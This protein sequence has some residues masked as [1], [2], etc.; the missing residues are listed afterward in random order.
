MI[1]IP[2]W[3]DT[4]FGGSPE[5]QLLIPLAM[6][7]ND[8]NLSGS[9][10]IAAN[11]DN[12]GGMPNLLMASASA[13]QNSDP[14]ISLEQEEVS[15]QSNGHRFRFSLGVGFRNDTLLWNIADIDNSPNILSELEWNDFRSTVFSGQ[16]RWSNPWHL[17]IR[18]GVEVGVVFDGENRDSDYLGDNRTQEF[19]RSYADTD[20]GSVFDAGLGMGY[21]FDIPW[22]LSSSPL[23]IIP[24]LGYAYHNQDVEDSNGRQVVSTSG[25]TPDPGPFPGLQSSY[26][27]RWDGPWLGID[28]ELPVGDRHILSASFEYHWADF[29]GDANWNLRNDFAHPSSFQHRAEGKGMF[30]SLGYAYNFSSNW[31]MNIGVKYCKM[32]TDPGVDTTFFADG[33][34]VSIPLNE[35]EWESYGINLGATYDF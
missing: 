4:V 23:H 21:R 29:E 20:D 11:F 7:L 26:D 13:G 27:A 16:F 35:V 19:S 33:S 1:A 12:A 32:T 9:D 18:G 14:G 8:K 6:E 30:L 34:Q 25:I 3:P 15:Q 31:A 10:A 5:N 24:L 17:F 22:Q 28:F 2:A